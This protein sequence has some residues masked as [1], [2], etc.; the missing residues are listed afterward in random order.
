MSHEAGRKQSARQ[1]VF[2][3]RTIWLALASSRDTY[4]RIDGATSLGSHTS[5]FRR[6]RSRSAIVF[7]GF[8]RV[9]CSVRLGTSPRTTQL[10]L[11][12]PK[13]K[14]DSAFFSVMCMK[15]TSGRMT[16]A[17]VCIIGLLC[18]TAVKGATDLQTFLV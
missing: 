3:R 15:T 14:L 18:S 12:P 16:I 1:T 13:R 9:L 2:A 4:I 6:F 5:C 10:N 7:H 11:G 17:W 8:A